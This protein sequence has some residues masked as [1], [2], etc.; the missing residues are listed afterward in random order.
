MQTSIYRTDWTKME[1]RYKHICYIT[2]NNLESAYAN[3]ILSNK[4]EQRRAVT[5][6][7]CLQVVHKSR[8]MNVL[9]NCYIKFFQ[10]NNMI[11]NEQAQKENQIF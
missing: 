7:A 11:I 6:M 5:N 2:S 10:H 9:E 8:Q 3:N 4:H 1:L